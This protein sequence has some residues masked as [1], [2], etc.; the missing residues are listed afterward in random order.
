MWWLKLECGSVVKLE[1][2]LWSYASERCTEI[3]CVNIG[4]AD[5]SSVKMWEVVWNINWMWADRVMCLSKWQR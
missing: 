5:S 2:I 3:C 4:S 1:K